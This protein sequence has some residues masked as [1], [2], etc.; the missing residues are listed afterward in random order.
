MDGLLLYIL[1]LFWVLM[2]LHVSSTCMLMDSS[3]VYSVTKAPVETVYLSTHLLLLYIDTHQYII[4]FITHFSYHSHITKLLL[5]KSSLKCDQHKQCEYTVIPVKCHIMN[6]YWVF[7]T[8]KLIPRH[9]V[10]N[11]VPTLNP[12]LLCHKK[13]SQMGTRKPICF[14]NAHL[15]HCNSSL[16]GLVNRPTISYW[17]ANIL[18]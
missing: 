10:E 3:N 5:H 8:Q 14:K 12:R 15:D 16:I 4:R 17:F 13:S 6:L 11:M 1:W 7:K 18:K 2:F 9:T